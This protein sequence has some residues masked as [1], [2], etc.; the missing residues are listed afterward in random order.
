MFNVSANLALH[1]VGLP[2]LFKTRIPMQQKMILLAVFGMGRFIIVAAFLCKVYDL[3]A[4]LITYSYLN[5]FFQEASVS[6]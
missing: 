4:P 1:V 5:W 3:Y 2:I 6:V